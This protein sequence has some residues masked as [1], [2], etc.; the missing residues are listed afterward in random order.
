[1]SIAASQSGDLYLLTVP[2]PA[3]YRGVTST[4]VGFAKIR[5]DQSQDFA[6]FRFDGNRITRFDICE[7]NWNFHQIQPLPNGELL[8]VCGRSRYRAEDDHDLNGK[9]FDENGTLKREF[10]LGDGIQDVQTTLDGRIWTSYFDE[11]VFGNFGWNDPIGSSGLILWDQFGNQLYEFSPLA[12]LDRICDCYALN[13]VSNT[14]TWCYYYTEFPLVCI[15]EQQVQA[16]WE[17]PVKGSDGFIL[18]R[19]FVLFRGGYDDHNLYHLFELLNDGKMKLRSV[20]QILDEEESV[21]HADM[22]ATRGCFLFLLKGT[23]CYRLDL[24]ELVR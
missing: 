21:L 6:I 22:I 8:L 17:S 15:R 23:N 18:W 4:G 12:G 20:Y 24:R 16:F 9:V 19:N 2:S 11:G 13:V 10:L 14:E 7:Q 5:T 3:D 1:M